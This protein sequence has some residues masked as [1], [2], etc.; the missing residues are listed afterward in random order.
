[1]TFSKEEDGL[2]E[3]N[4]VIHSPRVGRKSPVVSLQAQSTQ[5]P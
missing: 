2:L 1:M 4:G 5:K 3:I